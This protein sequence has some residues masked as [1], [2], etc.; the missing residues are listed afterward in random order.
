MGIY[1]VYPSFV[2]Q[3]IQKDLEKIISFLTLKIR[4]L[5]SLILT[6]GFGRGEG[7]VIIKNGKIKPLN[8]YDLVLIVE[9]KTKPQLLKKYGKILAKKLGMRF[10]DLIQIEKNRVSTLPLTQF[11]FDLKFGGR[12][13]YGESNI[14]KEIPQWQPFQIPLDSAKELLLNR[15]V[16]ILEC[17]SDDFLKRGLTRKEKEFLRTQLVKSVIA[18]CDVLLIL[19]TNYSCFL[20]E[21]LRNL[22]KIPGI[23]LGFLDWVN[24]AVEYKLKPFDFKINAEDWFQV[25]G[26]YEE[27][28]SLFFQQFYKKEFTSW[29]EFISYYLRKAKPGFLKR[30]VLQKQLPK[31]D[32]VFMSLLA[33]LVSHPKTQEYNQEL[34]QL[35]KKLL[36]KIENKETPNTE[37]GSFFL[38]GSTTPPTVEQRFIPE[39]GGSG[40]SPGCRC[41]KKFPSNWESLRKRAITL[42]YKILH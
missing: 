41:N 11:Y 13:I 37:A 24:K 25:R 6:G 3:K 4:D 40:Y 36:G 31:S 17:F 29:Q 21:K 1:T 19:N 14:L 26:F 23:T 5:C 18:C 12:V 39:H 10:V 22:K 20:K 8:D 35:A 32:L 15:L 38:R 9:K 28:V 33:L 2:D 27:T 16:T 34:I 42:S 30:L 7:S